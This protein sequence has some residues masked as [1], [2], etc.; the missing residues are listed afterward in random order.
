RGRTWRRRL[1]RVGAYRA[2]YNVAG[3]LSGR[4]TARRISDGGS[5]PH[6]HPAR[7]TARRAPASW[8]QAERPRMS[9]LE[10]SVKNVPT[11]LRK[12]LYVNWPIAV[13]LVTVACVG[14]LMLYSVA[15]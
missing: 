10:Y 12:I 3:A 6:P 11:G 5:W 14:F 2:R 8:S 15:G 4:S 9:Y 13:L 7:A 1:D